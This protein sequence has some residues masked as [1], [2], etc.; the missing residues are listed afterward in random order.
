MKSSEIRNAFVEYFKK[1]GHTHVGSSSLIPENDPTLLFANAGMNQFKNTFLGLEKRDY[2]RA[3]T[4]QKCVR[5]G[6]KH[7]DLENVGFTARHHTFFEMLGNF[8]FGDYF[9]KDAIHFAWEF[10]TKEL[11]IPKEKLYVTVHISDDEAAEIWHTQE[12]IPK[13]RI[14]RFDADNFWKMGDTGPCGPC[15]EI[16]YDHG[17]KAGTISDPFKGIAAG[18]DRFVEIW[19]LVFMQY[20]ENPPGTLTPLP[21]P[22]VDTGSGLERVVAAMQGKFNN[23][24][25]D[26]FMPMIERACKIGKIEYITDKEVLA[27][28]KHAAEITS[29]LR[30]LADHCRSTSFLI[31]DG[32]LPSN[33]GRGYVLR[34]IMRRAIR[35]G[36]K[37]SADQSFLPAMAEAL[38]E[39]MGSV[40]PE[41]SARR[42]HILNTIRDEEDRFISTLDNGTNIL[43]DE[44]AK[45]KAKG[46]KELAGEVV[47]RMYDT[48]G[49]PA[50]LTRVIANEQGIE[51][52]EAAFEKEMEANRAKSKASWKGKALGADEQHLIK[53]AKD[54]VATGKTVKFT[55]YGDF[56]GGGRITALSN[57]Q[58]VVTSLKEGD[59]GVIITDETSFYG[60]GGGQVGDI[61]YIMDKNGS[62]A[63]VVNTT[64]TDDI[65]LH[66][67]EVEHGEF[68]VGQEVDTIVNPFERRNTMSNHSATHLLHSA[69]RKVLGAHVTQAGSL[70]D[71]QK[72]RF[73]FTHNKPL[74]SEEIRQIEDLVNEQIAMGNE[75]KV[76]V[77]SPKEAQAKGAMAL[78]GEKY[79][80]KVRV[81]TMGDFSCELCGG[82]HVK[83]TSQI[84][85]FKIVSE[86]GVSAGVR[87]VEA[88]TGDG[89]VRYA[90]NAVSH[91]DE[92]LSAAGFQKSPH[93]LKHLEATGETATLANRVEAL[94]EQIK[95]MEKEM[96]KLQGGQVNVDDLA[97]KALTFKTKA[98]ASAKLVLADLALDDRQVL[99]EVT[100]H[101][102]NKIQNGVVVVVG[103]GE[104]SNPI[105]VS[106]SKE[107]SGETKAGDL[108]KEV[109]GIMGGKGGGRPDFAQGAAPNR[110][111]LPQA[112]DK[113][114]SLLGV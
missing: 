21:K 56:A 95:Q 98:G 38:I 91:L 79:G 65:V 39:S 30:V 13:D 23:Y 43:M 7:N 42:D 82:T 72:T 77:M 111:S 27:K 18:E 20:F 3:V 78:F 84:R 92:A 50:D 12:G 32:A 97:A 67:V 40:Y 107:I 74:S 80:D 86:A 71:S 6:G 60:E 2:S 110:A 99:A 112:F 68:K 46:A 19:N 53:F 14:F 69:L 44:I 28:D 17:P 101:L 35:Y 33:E 34:R 113:V 87:R 93:Y 48:Y 73:D 55:G 90:M 54:Y 109:A 49:F 52:N 41:L 11:N 70:V 29:A 76:E 16:F 5:A 22:S 94:K 88:I 62:R 37:L 66:H 108:L 24:D 8:S 15:T 89:A 59:H 106:V 47:F 103:Q 45:A 100:D 58:E 61:G 1:K 10:L 81:L 31:A 64:K 51:V 104:G 102:K 85:L 96:K 57:G 114:K 4:V 75:V 83:N 63:K 9:K 25:T 26:L 105:I 36:R